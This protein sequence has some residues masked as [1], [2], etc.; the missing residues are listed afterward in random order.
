MVTTCQE[1]VVEALTVAKAAELCVKGHA[2]HDDQIKA[3]FDAVRHAVCDTST[4]K[5]I[6]T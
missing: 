4:T 1:E 2:G 3:V 5:A 6:G